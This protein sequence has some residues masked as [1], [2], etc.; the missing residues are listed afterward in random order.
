MRAKPLNRLGFYAL[1]AI[2]WIG[3]AQAKTCNITGGGVAFGAY[4]PTSSASLDTTGSVAL[5]C[6]GSFEVVLSL[7]VGN[8][9]GASYSGG[10]KMTRGRGSGTLT[11]NLYANA[12]RTHVLGDGTGGSVTLHINGHRTYIQAIW[13]RI[14]RGQHTVLAGSYADI[15][16]ATIS[17]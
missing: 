6:E 12:A 9:A 11:Y 5:D 1:L 2:A 13:A 8:G 14:P 17:Y 4:D 16:V 7:S 3:S 10:R 15:V